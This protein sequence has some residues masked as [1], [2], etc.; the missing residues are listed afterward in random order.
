MSFFYFFLVVNIILAECPN[1]CSGH[2]TCTSS[3]TC[4]CNKQPGLGINQGDFSSFLYQGADC[5]ERI[6]N[7]FYKQ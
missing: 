2:G 3:G 7:W 5:S 4:V 1:S 6:Y